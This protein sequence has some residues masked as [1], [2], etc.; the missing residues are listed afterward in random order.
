MSGFVRAPCPGTEERGETKAGVGGC[1]RR[2]KLVTGLQGLQT[3]ESSFLLKDSLTC[4]FLGSSE[5]YVH[6]LCHEL[7]SVNKFCD[8]LLLANNDSTVDS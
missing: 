3:L 6:A 2:M 1:L 4:Q 7:L 8:L 5:F